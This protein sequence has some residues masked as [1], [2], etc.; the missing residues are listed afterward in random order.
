MLS[1]IVSCGTLYSDLPCS[2]GAVFSL[3]DEK[4]GIAVLYFTS[5]H[6]LEFP[7]NPVS[8][9]GED[10][11]ITLSDMS[12]MTAGYMAIKIT[13]CMYYTY[14]ATLHPYSKQ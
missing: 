10:T 2:P 4:S 8:S 5:I 11:V 1:G 6:N 7:C 13:T 9:S 14:I 12:S 3:D